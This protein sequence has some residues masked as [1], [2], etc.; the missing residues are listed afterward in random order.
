MFGLREEGKEYQKEWKADIEPPLYGQGIRL[1]IEPPEGREQVLGKGGKTPNREGLSIALYD[2]VMNQKIID[3]QDEKVVGKDAQRGPTI[4]GKG[5]G[6]ADVVV[7]SFEVGDERLADEETGD[8]EKD[9]DTMRHGHVGKAVERRIEQNSLGMALYHAKDGES[10][11]QIHSKD[12]LAVNIDAP[13]VLHL[14]GWLF[15]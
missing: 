4:E 8:D 5:F 13:K 3:K 15:Q 11:Q 2:L 12:A 1:P 9:V 6:T 10:P 7:V 14:F